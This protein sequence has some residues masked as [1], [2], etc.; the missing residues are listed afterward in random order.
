MQ[1]SD[2]SLTGTLAVTVTVTNAYLS[3]LTISPGTLSPTFH[4]QTTNYNVTVAD[5]VTSVTVTPTTQHSG[6]TVTVNNV[7]VTSGSASDAIT[8]PAGDAT[9]NITVAVTSE[10]GT[11]KTYTIEVTRASANAY[12]SD[13]TISPGTLSPTF[14][15]QT[16]NYNV[17]VADTVT[18][19][20][21]TPTTQRSGA[22]VMVNNVAVTSGS[23]SDAIS[24]TAGDPISVVATSSNGMVSRA[25]IINVRRTAASTVDPRLP[26]PVTK[27]D[28]TLTGFAY[29]PAEITFGDP[30]PALTA[31]SGARTPVAYAATPEAVC[32]VDSTTGA[33]TITGGGTCTITAMAQETDDYLEATATVDVEVLMVD[34]TLHVDTIAGDDIINVDE[35][36][37]GFDI[38]GSTGT[39]NDVPV[40]GTIDDIPVGSAISDRNGNWSVRVPAATPSITQGTVVIAVTATHPD[41]SATMTVRREVPV[42]LTPDLPLPKAVEGFSVEA[43]FVEESYELSWEDPEDDTIIRYEHRWHQQASWSE[44]TEIPAS[45]SDPTSYSVIAA[46]AGL[47]LHTA[48][49]CQIRA[50]NARGAGPWSEDSANALRIEASFDAAAYT[51]EE[52]GEAVTITVRLGAPVG[53]EVRIPITV[54]AGTAK[55]GDYEVEG[56]NEGA[57][58]F[59]VGD[60]GLSERTRTFTI[61]AADEAESDDDYDDETVR[62]SFGDLPLGLQAGTPA[63]ATLTIIDDEGEVI[64]ARFQRLNDAILS[65]HALALA[66][67]TI[68]AVTSRQAAGPGCADQ[69][70]TV[71][72]GGQSSLAE[73]LTANAQRLNTGPLDLKQ[74]LGTSA[75]RLRLTDDADTDGPGCFTM[76]GQGDYRNLSSSDAPALAWDGDLLTGQVG[77]DALV[78]ADLRAGLAV[79]WSDGAFDYTDRTAGGPFGGA[80]RSRLMSV[81]PYVTWWSPFGLDLWATGGFGWGK[82]ELDD[83]KAGTHTNDTTLRLASVGASGPLP[84][85]ATLLA[86]GTT[87]V[88]LKAQA[89]VAQMDVE[90]HRA[91]H[92]VAAQRLR[93]ALEGRH[94]RTLASGAQIAP[95]MEVG[96][97][98]DGGAGATGT[99]L[100]LGAGL[101]YVNPDL[102]LTVE[103][104]GRVLAA[105]KTDYEEWGASGLIQVDPGTAG[106][107]LSLSV[108]PS[109]GATTSGVERLWNQGLDGLGATPQAAG[110]LEAV[111]GYGLPTWEGKGLLTPYGGVT[112]TGQGRRLRLGGTLTVGPAFNLSLE[113]TQEVQRV[114]P[115]VYGVL[116]Q[117]EWR[118]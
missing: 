59:R 51:A 47:D 91:A 5:T 65:K 97:R 103:G 2:G 100:E 66:D 81:H 44:W 85:G 101:R 105:Y 88:R 64:R 31:P 71:S 1:A 55:P 106:Q 80:Y 115:T 7:A 34:L 68:A 77:A 73:I 84:I 4:P 56:L 17:T 72:F 102:G 35:H 48:Y 94:E 70:S 96:L 75:F 98:H 29:D 74:L 63:T 25:Y 22:T 82:I 117:A 104:R 69:P 90:G 95:L 61:T 92:S 45:R 83:Q 18:S 62:L 24:I 12:L 3:D 21:V 43:A 78:R 33:L 50:V 60:D 67:V 86:E 19:V 15:P 87:T 53:H 8:L 40:E 108:A 113:S 49:T 52:G 99:G 38:T 41:R 76:W 42:D 46:E 10:D 11:T 26:P 28:Q 16:T 107:G 118:F 54:T 14:H 58:T 36:R 13:L 112:L 6:A 79:S 9:H 37:A 32:S 23:T 111:L 20:T 109:Y 89:S 27:D 30:A 93:L 116:L 57:L 114:T 110:R 39:L